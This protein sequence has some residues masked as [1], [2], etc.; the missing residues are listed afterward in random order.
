MLFIKQH[1]GSV[2]SSAQKV[3][4]GYSPSVLQQ[5]VSDLNW[6][7]NGAQTQAGWNATIQFNV[8]TGGVK[9]GATMPEGQSST[10]SYYSG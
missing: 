5:S 4:T 9:A 3:L 6:A 10:G 1:P 2:I 7:T 8:A